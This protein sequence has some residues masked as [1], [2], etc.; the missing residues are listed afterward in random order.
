MIASD[1]IVLPATA[2]DDAK[3]YLRVAGNNEDALIAALLRSAAELCEQS[4]GRC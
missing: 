4:A 3:A 2:T 1:A